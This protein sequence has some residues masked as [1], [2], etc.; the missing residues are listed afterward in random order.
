MNDRVHR[1][2][3]D[4]ASG[5]RRSDA[6][7]DGGTRRDDPAMPSL[8]PMFPCSTSARAQRTT[9]TA[10]AAVAAMEGAAMGAITSSGTFL[11]DGTLWY[12][13]LTK[14]HIFIRYGSHEFRTYR[15]KP[16][17]FAPISRCA[18]LHF[19][20]E[21]QGTDMNFT[22]RSVCPLLKRIAFVRSLSSR[23]SK[24]K[25]LGCKRI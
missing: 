8:C 14:S 1:W 5:C 10:L 12:F 19:V 11:G 16:S 25:R 7:D 2:K 24:P 22:S 6:G 20:S 9:H 4:V 13:L 21:I 15:Q 18:W 17:S 3:C 23:R